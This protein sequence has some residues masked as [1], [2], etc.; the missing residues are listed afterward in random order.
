M[1]VDTQVA[2]YNVSAYQSGALQE[3]DVRYLGQLNAGAVPYLVQLAEDS[4]PETAGKAA[5]VLE[6]C[7]YLEEWVADFRSWNYPAARAEE[8]VKPYV[9]AE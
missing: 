1:D 6:E 9:P 8:L 7:G 5:A 2:R 3:V 4:D